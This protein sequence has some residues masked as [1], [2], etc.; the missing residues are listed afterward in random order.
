MGCAWGLGTGG[1]LMAFG[2]AALYNSVSSTALSLVENPGIILVDYGSLYIV[3][4]IMTE[5]IKLSAISMNA[6]IGHT[7]VTNKIRETYQGQLAILN[8]TI[9][10]NEI[11]TNQSTIFAIL[12]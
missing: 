11:R 6:V 9:K 1:D 7:V 5:N 8:Q 3:S 12:G 10:L 4:G 2:Y